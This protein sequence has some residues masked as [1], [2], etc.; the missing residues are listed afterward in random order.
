MDAWQRYSQGGFGKQGRHGKGL[1]MV[2]AGK[3]SV[4]VGYTLSSYILRN[5]A[6]SGRPERAKFYQT[7]GKS[8]LGPK[9]LHRPTK[10]LA[11]KW[12]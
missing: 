6:R 10:W 11:G 4:R 3:R 2:G 5:R 1:L 9:R 8:P 7:Q 12:L